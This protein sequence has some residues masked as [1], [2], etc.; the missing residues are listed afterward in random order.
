VIAPDTWRSDLLLIVLRL[1][2]LLGGIVCV[3]SVILAIKHDML[4]LALL[5][6]IALAVVLA[7][8]FARRVPG[9]LRAAGACLVMYAVGVGLMISVGSISQIYLFGFSILSTLLLSV[10]WGVGTVVLNSVTMLAIGYLGI[11]APEMVVPRWEVG[12]AS[13][14]IIT[15]NFTFV[16]ASLV[17]ALGAVIGALE[18]A[19]DRSVSAREA[20]ERDQHDLLTL[21]EALHESR[22]LLRIAGTTARI[23][24]WR[25]DLRAMQIVWSDEVCELHEMPPDTTLTPEEALDFY[26]PE[27]REP[28]SQAF[29]RCAQDGTPFEQEA[30]IVGKRGTRLW[31][32]ALGNPLRSDTGEITHI[33]GALQDISH[34][35]L[36]E[37]QQDKLRV[38]LWQ[39]QKMDAVGRLAGGVAHDF[40]NMLSVI[41]SYSQ[42][43]LDSLA[44]GDP[45]RSDLLEVLGAA[46]RSAD[47]TKQLLAF[48]RQQPAMPKVIELNQT[49]GDMLKMLERMIGE[50]IAIVWKPGPAL[51]RIKMDSTQLDQIVTNLAVN[52][53]D[54]IAGVGQLVIETSNVTFDQAYCDANIGA[55]VGNFVR[56]SVTDNG[57]GMDA[58]M[59][60]KLFEPFFTTKAVGKGTGL[61]LATVYGIVQ[62]NGGFLSVYSE[63]G[64]GSTFH[65]CLPQCAEEAVAGVKDRLAPAP[66]RGTATVLL[67]EDAEALLRLAERMLTGLGYR[68]IATADPIEAI[69]L[70]A[71]H[72]DIDLLLTDVIMPR[73]T[74]REL[75][76]K[77][78][79]TRRDL[80]CLFMSGYSADVIS[81]RGVVED[82]VHFLQKPFSQ[83]A[84]AQKV[85]EALER[86]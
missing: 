51:W 9:E 11:A 42:F 3:P 26:A 85:R 79:S 40:N 32:R 14:S 45:R 43:T 71:Q 33:H 61:G 30:E 28:I 54:A 75:W 44:E 81:H 34:Q 65:V 63:P 5:D 20:L 29:A 68:V 67:V 21:N 73:M 76:E 1:A 86:A 56:L 58:A 12:L 72:E 17:L 39:A 15:A 80:K 36:A 37:A 47:L 27:W 82:G 84:L 18:S 25:V 77:L 62:Q 24:G 48:A 78:S 66:P 69:A 16:N 6:I 4:G 52:A 31:V 38:Q 50:D 57:A 10:R 8:T 60:G 59:L 74:G 64:H 49:V 41:M 55:L 7:L 70:G 22:T 53:R 23:G 19:L 83:E 2:S 13:W 35:K 46:R